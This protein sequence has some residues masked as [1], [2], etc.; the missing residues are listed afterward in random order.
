LRV[1]IDYRE[2]PSGLVEL[3][4]CEEVDIE[5]AK[6]AYGDYLINDAITIERKTGRDFL[7]SL[8]DGR[9][10]SQMSNLKRYCMHPVLLIEGSPFK[11]DLAFDER[12]IRGALI[13]IQAIWYVPVLYSRSKEDSRDIMLMIG[14]QEEACSNVI[15]LRGG[16]RPRRLKS[17]QL[18]ILQGLPKIGPRAAKRLLDHFGS[19]SAV[20]NA[21]AESL[22]EVDGIGRVSAEKIRE[23]LDSVYEAT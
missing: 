19:V 12:A 21:T 16:Y 6:V 23:V 1:T 11:T 20:M 13:S 4:R 8:I 3:L 14:K 2:K 9:L 17:R 7:I 18:F 22:M 5:I 15:P 10:F